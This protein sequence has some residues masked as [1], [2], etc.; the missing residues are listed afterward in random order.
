MKN[1]FVGWILI[2]YF[3]QCTHLKR[4]PK[5]I[6]K[7][8]VSISWILL[9][10]HR[11]AAV[12]ANKVSYLPEMDIESVLGIGEYKIPSFVAIIW[13]TR[14]HEYFIAVNKQ[15]LCHHGGR[16]LFQIRMNFS[17]G[18]QLPV[19]LGRCDG[20]RIGSRPKFICNVDCFL[21]ISNKST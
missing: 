16:V 13:R 19:K 8:C 21:L 10:I 2:N 17:A 3:F 11:Y 5:C 1:S 18:L 20:N 12:W 14:T 15:D 9:L 4:N 6:L 7:L